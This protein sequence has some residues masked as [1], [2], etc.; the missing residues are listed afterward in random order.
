MAHALPADEA[1]EPGDG[2]VLEGLL[3]QDAYEAAQAFLDRVVRP[4]MPDDIVIASCVEF[5]SA[6]T[7]G[8]NSRAFL[9]DGE[10][11]RAL[12]GNGPVVVPKS[13]ADPYLGGSGT[14]ISA[15]L[16][17]EECFRSWA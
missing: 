16:G 3:L 2:P 11:R 8:Y 12:A 7:F 17:E 6:W 1:D 4:S 13:G 5:P 10:F 14:P 9:S 15:Q